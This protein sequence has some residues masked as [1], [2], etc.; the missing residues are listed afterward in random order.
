MSERPFSVSVFHGLTRVASGD[1]FVFTTLGAAQKY[2]L[3]LA[4]EVG[5]VP[6]DQLTITVFETRHG[7]LLNQ[8]SITASKLDEAN[9]PV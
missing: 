8:I 4:A 3:D 1:S 2:G 5:D 9:L 7:R 6:L